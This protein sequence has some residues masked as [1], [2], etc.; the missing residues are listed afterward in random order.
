MPRKEKSE[1]VC[2]C[3]MLDYA[4]NVFPQLRSSQA[5]PLAVVNLDHFHASASKNR[6]RSWR[7]NGVIFSSPRRYISHLESEG[8]LLTR[9]HA[10][11]SQPP[12]TDKSLLVLHPPAVLLQVD[13]VLSTATLPWKV[14]HKTC[15]RFA[16]TNISRVHENIGFRD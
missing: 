9:R 10:S 7:N 11:P 3:Q 16:Q 12:T 15:S 5:L 8:G 1:Y 4:L 13:L 6:F 2:Y 14:K